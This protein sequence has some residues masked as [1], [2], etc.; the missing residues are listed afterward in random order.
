MILA[1]LSLLLQAPR[2][3]SRRVLPCYGVDPS[4]MFPA[5]A[6]GGVRCVVSGL[7]HCRAASV[8]ARPPNRS[9]RRTV[10]SRR[11]V[12]PRHQAS[13]ARSLLPAA[14]LPVAVLRREGPVV[15]RRLVRAGAVARVPAVEDPALRG[16]ARLLVHPGHRHVGNLRAR[17]RLWSRFVLGAPAP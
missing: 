5:A 15:S 6:V 10:A 12:D 1:T 13:G 14:P 3:A 11:A 8:H 7:R 2:Y 4:A 17:S 9:D 16:A